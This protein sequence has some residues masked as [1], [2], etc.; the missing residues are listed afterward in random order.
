MNHTP[1][2]HWAID[3][4]AVPQSTGDQLVNA[5]ADLVGDDSQKLAIRSETQGAMAGRN[6]WGNKGDV[7]FCLCGTTTSP[8]SLL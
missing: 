2:S 7:R 6:L 5:T 8:H 4:T 1:P 3:I